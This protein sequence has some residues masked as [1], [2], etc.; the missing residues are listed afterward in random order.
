LIAYAFNIAHA[1]LSTRSSY[2]I[3]PKEASR[4]A[5]ALYS[6]YALLNTDALSC[7]DAFPN[8][9][10]LRITHAGA[11]ASAPWVAYVLEITG[12]YRILLLV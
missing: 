10:A 7:A 2:L 8:A 5:Y 6:A 1:I 3:A 11:R 12:I 9:G 4:I